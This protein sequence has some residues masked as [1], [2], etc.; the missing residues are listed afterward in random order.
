MESMQ[1]AVGII[2]LVL[3]TILASV[4]LLV[5]RRASVPAGD[6]APAD[7]SRYRAPL[8][9]LLIVVGIGVSYGTLV[10]WPY[11]PRKAASGEPVKVTVTGSIWSWDINPTRLPAGKPIV[12][13][14]TSRDVNH[15]FGIYDPDLKMLTQV[16]A[17][18]GYINKVHY[19]FPRAGT[20]KIMCLEYCGL[21]HHAMMTDL[22]IDP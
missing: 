8:L 2:T 11:G 14:V 1:D 22:T 7:P 13:A 12:F 17:M 3:V 20:Y 15:G 18:P 6:V 9:W 4:F 19:T 21:A 5:L 10:D 16:Q